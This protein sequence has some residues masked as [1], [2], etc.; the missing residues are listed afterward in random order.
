[1]PEKVVSGYLPLSRKESAPNSLFSAARV[2]IVSVFL[3]EAVFST[4]AKGWPGKTRV[5]FMK[6]DPKSKPRM[7]AA[8]SVV[9]QLAKVRANIARETPENLSLEV[10]DCLFLLATSL[11]NVLYSLSI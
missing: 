11:L 5:A 6:V 3:L 10:V 4:I 8:T 9:K 7:L 2:T 1:M